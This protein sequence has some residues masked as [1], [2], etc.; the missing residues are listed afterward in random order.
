MARVT[1]KERD[2]LRGA[3]ETANAVLPRMR[4]DL[5]KLQQRIAH[6][7]AVV[8]AYEALLGKREKLNG[9]IDS[10]IAQKKTRAKR[11][12]VSEQIF[13]VMAGKELEIREIRDAIQREFGV[14]YGRNTIFTV[15]KRETSKFH[16]VGENRWRN[17]PLIATKAS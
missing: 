1:D 12:L 15:L 9:A 13:M 11:G 14:S 2:A 6:M 7:E 5:Q 10:A 16:K 4:E 17:N 3:A 8:F